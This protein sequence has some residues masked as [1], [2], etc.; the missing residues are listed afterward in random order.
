MVR[1][2]GTIGGNIAY[3]D[4]ASDL[5]TA[6]V[7]LG[8]TI[9]VVGPRG[10]RALAADEFFTGLFE[11]ALAENEIITAISCPAEASGTGSAYATL[12]NP[13]SRYALIGAAVQVTI[14]DGTCT[15]ATVAVGGLTPTATRAPS[16]EAAL[17]G[18]ALTSDVIE[19]AAAM[20]D[21]DLGDDI[22]GD[23]HASAAYRRQMIPVG[24]AQALHKAVERAA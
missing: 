6:L 2:R 19:A 9:E 15:A 21:A 16:V 11:T 13:A 4:P 20:V 18:K 3:A 8:A 22:L 5:P 14:A 17:V 24:V 23:I 10:R 7:A 1:N 12:M